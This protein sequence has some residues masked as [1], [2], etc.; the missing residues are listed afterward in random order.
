MSEAPA[1]DAVGSEAWR[2]W[3]MASFDTP[4]EPE[5]PAP[6]A[7]DP[8]PDPEVLKRQWRAQAEAQGREE[9]YAHGYEAGLA[10]GRASGQQAGWQAGQQD[11]YA[12]GLAEGR[13]LARQEGLQLAALSAATARSLNQLEEQMGQAL[14][15]LALDVAG[16]ILRTTLAEQPHSMLEAVR[17]V[18]RMPATGSGGV[19][20]L[21]VHPL[22]L[23]LVRQHLA[24]ELR[25]GNWRVLADESISRGG[26]RAESPLGDIDATLQTRWR[27]VAASLGRATAWEE[28]A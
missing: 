23:E 5:P 25:D 21:W 19:L 15:T 8:G 28:S 14:L 22:D 7:A 18:L 1:F 12:A 9:G 17:E 27:R 4:P 6:A 3:Q 26:C 11:G 2:R 13:E 20:R 24:E 16:Q 10:E